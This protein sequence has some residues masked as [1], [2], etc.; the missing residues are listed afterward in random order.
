MV[1][2]YCIA[3]YSIDICVAMQYNIIEG[4]PQDART[5]K[6]S[7][8]LRNI[9]TLVMNKYYIGQEEKLAAAFEIKYDSFVSS[10]DDETKCTTIHYI[11]Y[12]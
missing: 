8:M 12:V 6:E 2:I 10:Y 9:E 1:F 3:A 4:K 7:I 11:L 5:V